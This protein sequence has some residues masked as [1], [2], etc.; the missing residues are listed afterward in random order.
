M[1]NSDLKATQMASVKSRRTQTKEKDSSVE[2]TRDGKGRPD[3]WG[4][5]GDERWGDKSKQCIIYMHKITK[6]QI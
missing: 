5:E 1:D 2:T 4:K 3:N 6:E